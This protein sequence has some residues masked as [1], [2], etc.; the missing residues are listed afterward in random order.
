MSRFA[1]SRAVYTCFAVAAVNRD[2]SVA[3]AADASA[4]PV[5][6]G[7]GGEDLGRDCGVFAAAEVL[8]LAVTRAPVMVHGHRCFAAGGDRSE[9]PVDEQVDVVVAGCV[10]VR[11]DEVICFG[12][13]DGSVDELRANA[14]ENN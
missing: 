9:S 10:A 2:E 1:C 6:N 13:F 8:D 11:P 14:G 4:R 5:V 12:F 7:S 3:L